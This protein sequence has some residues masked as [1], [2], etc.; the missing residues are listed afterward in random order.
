MAEQYSYQEL[1]EMHLV[2]GECGCIAREA[3]RKYAEKYPNRRHPNH[4]TFTR[5]HQTA[6]ETGSFRQRREGGSTESITSRRDERILEAIDSNPNLSTR[7]LQRRLEVSQSTVWRTLHE[8][9]EE[10]S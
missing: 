5:I 7:S 4:K 9:H 1:A 6:C 8:D 10:E 2:Y 3:A